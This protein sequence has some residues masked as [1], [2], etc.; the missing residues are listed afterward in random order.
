MGRN[1]KKIRNVTS[2]ECAKA[3]SKT[4]KCK[5]IEY[6]RSSGRTDT[7][8]AFSEGDCLLN[9]GVDIVNPPCDADYYQMYFWEQGDKVDCT[10]NEPVETSEVAPTE[11]NNRNKN[12]VCHAYEET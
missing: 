6:F 4:K 7:S 11:T 1:I 12:K 5:G 10:T 9:D 2:E 8:S 3:C